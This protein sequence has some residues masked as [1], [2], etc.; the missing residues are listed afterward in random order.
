MTLKDIKDEIKKIKDEAWDNEMAHSNE[1][2]L[3][4]DVLEEIAS[5]NLSKEE[6]ILFA[7]EVLKTSNISFAR[8]CA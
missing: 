5:G 7:K 1:D 6:C 8:W 3:R 2:S 4:E